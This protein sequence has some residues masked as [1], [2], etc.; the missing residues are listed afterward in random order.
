MFKYTNGSGWGSHVWAG[1][2]EPHHP[3][4]PGDLVSFCSGTPRIVWAWTLASSSF[5]MLVTPAFVHSF[6]LLGLRDYSGFLIH[7]P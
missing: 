6:I 7:F 4:Q 1:V 5:L 2:P 3:R